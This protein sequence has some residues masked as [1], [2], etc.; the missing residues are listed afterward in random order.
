MRGDSNGKVYRLPMRNWN[1]ILGKEPIGG[2]IG[3]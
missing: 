3:L 1:R 2:E